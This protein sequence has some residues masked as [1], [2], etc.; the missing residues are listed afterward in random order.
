MVF[1][2]RGGLQF[3]YFH[4]KGLIIVLVFHYCKDFS[5]K[6]CENVRTRGCETVR[7]VKLARWPRGVVSCTGVQRN[8]VIAYKMRE[9]PV[10]R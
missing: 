1:W 3:G 5:L 2:S 6:F 10:A 9:N 8:A 4:P 7:G